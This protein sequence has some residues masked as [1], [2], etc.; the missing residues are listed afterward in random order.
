M[1]ETASQEQ[2]V[3]SE[4][5]DAAALEAA[6]IES[7]EGPKLNIVEKG[8]A[9]AT[10]MQELGLNAEQVGKRVGCSEGTVRCL[11]RLL[12]LSDEIL[13]FLE[14]G[15]LGIRQGRTLLTVKDVEVRGALARTAVEEG[16]SPGGLKARAQQSVERE[17]EDGAGTAMSVARAW[18]DVLGVEVG[19]RTLGRGG[20]FRIEV[21]FSS[22]E[23]ALAQARWLGK[24]VARGSKGS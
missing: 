9:Y 4:P 18:G 23:A 17:E 20:G 6:L 16:W 19:V 1:S 21:G 2:V 11:T 12:G 15:E 22:A 24:V 3:R 13:G 7:S 8:R 14:R 5:G 10:L